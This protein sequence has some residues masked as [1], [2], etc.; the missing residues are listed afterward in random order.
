M[1]TSL[2]PKLRRPKERGISLIEVLVSMVVLSMGLLGVAGLQA[3]VTKYK[4]NSWSRTAVSSLVSDFADRVR[5][6]SDVA[7]SN[8][9]TGVA[10][11]SLYLINTKWA[12]QQTAT[13]TTPSPNCLTASCTTA[14][15]AAFDLATWRQLVRANLP[16]GA[17]FIRGD[18][19]V[20]IDVTLMWF[21]KEFTDKG[22]AT[23]TALLTSPTCAATDTGLAQQKCCPQGA[24]VAAGVRCATFSF[25]P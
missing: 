12:D 13:L 21:D 10:E 7:G 6:N 2:A 19:S 22:N 1:T 15:R 4:I 14:Q 5:M 9:I 18:R 24:D 16:Q 8:Y 17:A 11:P 23:D 25:I 3:S 20:G